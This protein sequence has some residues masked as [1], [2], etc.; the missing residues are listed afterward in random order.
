MR[1][2]RRRV[3]TSSDDG[4]AAFISRVIAANA[5]PGTQASAARAA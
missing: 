1:R 3:L 2:W 5:R 4:E